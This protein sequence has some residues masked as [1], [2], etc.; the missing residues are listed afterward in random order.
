MSSS[1]RGAARVAVF[2]GLLAVLTI[3]ADV[4]VAQHLKSVQLLQS[5][6]VAVPLAA[7][8]ALTALAASRQA[9]FIRARSVH[10]NGGRW[11]TR[12]AW[13]GLYA[14]VTGGIALAVYGG[15]RA[16]Q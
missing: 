3:P 10:A 13:A 1:R 2:F 9:R 6:Y 12:F 4:L 16:A 14:A 8:F 7:V 11:A 15:L 5:L